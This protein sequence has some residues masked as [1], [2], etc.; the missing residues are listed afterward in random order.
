[1]SVTGDGEGREKGG[2]GPM[3][4]S[5]LMVDS[6]YGGEFPDSINESERGEYPIQKIQRK[7]KHRSEVVKK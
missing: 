4:S 6:K 3:K 2:K 1:M 7:L 5:L